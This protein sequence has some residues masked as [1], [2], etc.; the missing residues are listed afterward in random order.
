[1]I[2]SNNF[3]KLRRSIYNLLHTIII[4]EIILTSEIIYGD[5]HGII[6]TINQY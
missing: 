5:D 3:V 6:S 2:M 1:M 4:N